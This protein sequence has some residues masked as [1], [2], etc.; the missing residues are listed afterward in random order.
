MGVPHG[1]KPGPP[2]DQE[3]SEHC[4]PGWL[5]GPRLSRAWRETR[6]PRSP[7]SAPGEAG[8]DGG[9]VVVKRPPGVFDHTDM[10]LPAAPSRRPPCPCPPPELRNLPADSCPGIPPLLNW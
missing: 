3:R 2:A 10:V 4:R 8:S 1:G 6:P 7:D 9:H 5:R